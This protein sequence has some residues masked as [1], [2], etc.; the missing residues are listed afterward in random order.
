MS[1]RQEVAEV[2]ALQALGWLAADSDRLA[3][4]LAFSGAAPAELRDR[5]G[6]PKFL[7]AVL[8]FVMTEDERVLAFSAF[9]AL[10]PESVAR[11]RTGLPGGDLPAWT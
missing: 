10:A 7:A 2:V 6:E 9:A 4:F 3:G 1:G 5:T 8:D 11:A